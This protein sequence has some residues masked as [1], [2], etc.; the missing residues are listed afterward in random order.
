RVLDMQTEARSAQQYRK[1]ISAMTDHSSA[2]Y[3]TITGLK[4]IAV[5]AGELAV[6]ADDLK[7]PEELSIFA[8]EI[9][10]LIQH[11]AELANAENRGYPMFAGTRSDQT[12]FSVT[13]NA[14]GNV[15]A[16]DYAGNTD[17]A[18]AEINS[19]VTFGVHNPGVNNSGT[20][21]RGLVTDSRFGADL[22]NHLISLQDNLNSGNIAAIKSTDQTNL[23]ADEE[24]LILQMADNGALR[25]R[26]EQSNS[27]AANRITS[28]EKGI[29]DEVD[30]DL[31]QTLVHLNR[32][33]NAYTAALQT[34]GT[35]LNKS[36]LDYLR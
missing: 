22:F 5:R 32:T 3:G 11:A 7:S 24:H 9:T 2:A 17:T 1:N 19:G 21:P 6:R 25:S 26:L 15:T 28:L 14:A 12:P 20:G 23:R 30:A 27:L 35:I 29:S 31:A 13:T 34:A 10:Q 4:N 16:V 36:L 18:V 8:R 33:Q